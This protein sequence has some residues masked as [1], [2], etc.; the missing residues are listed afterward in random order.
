MN[1]AQARERLL[2]WVAIPAL[3]A[4]L[5]GL[6]VLQYRWSGQVSDATRAQMLANLHMSL[7]SFRQDFGHELGAVAVEIRTIADS[8]EASNP[9][10]LNEQFHRLQQTVAHPNLVSHI[11]LWAD[12]THQQ[13]LRFDPASGQFERT[14]WPAEFDPMQQRL[15]EITTA[16]HPPA[17]GPEAHGGP[18]H[19]QFASRRNF[20]GRARAAGRGAA[21][22]GRMME[23]MPWAID[24]SIP[25]VAY[26]IRRHASSDGPVNGADVTWLIIQLNPGVLQKEIFPE[27]AQKFFGSASGMDYYV[28]VKAVGNEGERVV[29]SSLTRFVIRFLRCCVIVPIETST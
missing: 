5:A 11:Y 18:R 10:E 25:A 21:M 20:D 2:R 8:P 24:Q 15:L 26:P 28:T 22:R 13:P 4:V 1:R 3:A 7:M 19:S 16:H 14:A 17:G 29:Y 12:P 6:A 9:K 23:M 27:L